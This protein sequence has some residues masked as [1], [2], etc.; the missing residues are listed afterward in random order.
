MIMETQ[1][2]MMRQALDDHY[3]RSHSKVRDRETRE[4]L[5]HSNFEIQ[6]DTYSQFLYQGCLIAWECLMALG[7]VLWALGS[8]SES[9]FLYY[10]KNGWLVVATE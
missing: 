4:T 3:H 6:T 8:T 10:K 7:F 2:T 1:H 5:I 9:P